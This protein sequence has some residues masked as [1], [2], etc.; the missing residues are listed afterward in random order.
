MISQTAEHALR[1]LIYLARLDGTPVAAGEIA[2]AI[3]AP[4]NYLGKTLQTLARHGYVVGAR[5]PSGGFRLAMDPAAIT[6][7]DLGRV[8]SEAPRSRICLLGGMTCSDEHACIAHHRWSAV[9]RAVA[10]TLEETSVADLA[11]RDLDG[12]EMTVV[13]PHTARVAV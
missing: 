2:S 7:A 4:A 5:G 12:I 8:F 9:Q 13:K 6:I 11:G 3:G 10:R 1:A